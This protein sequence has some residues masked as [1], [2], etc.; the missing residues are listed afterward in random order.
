MDT[1]NPATIPPGP[2]GITENAKSARA[3]PSGGPAPTATSSV[4][5]H[6][7]PSRR[8]VGSYGMIP[9]PVRRVPHN[10]PVVFAAT[11]QYATCL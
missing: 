11:Y 7:R 4:F 8:G 9:A 10:G 5:E 2:T 6:V 3:D 1:R